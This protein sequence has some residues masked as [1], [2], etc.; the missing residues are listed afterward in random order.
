M[1]TMGDMMI[2]SLE[3]DEALS[4]QTT[5]CDSLPIKVVKATWIDSARRLFGE[6]KDI[7]M[8]AQKH[9][10]LDFQLRYEY[11]IL[12]SDSMSAVR[13]HL[14]MTLRYYTDAS[15]SLRDRDLLDDDA[16]GPMGT[17]QRAA[18]PETGKPGLVPALGMLL[19]KTEGG[20]NQMVAKRQHF[21]DLQKAKDDSPSA[22]AAAQ[23]DDVLIKSPDVVS[24]VFAPH[25]IHAYLELRY[26]KARE[27]RMTLLR[28]LNFFRSVER[29]LVH[30]LERS[31]WSDRDTLDPMAFDTGAP[32]R[33]ADGTIIKP[34]LDL[35]HALE[36]H[37]LDKG[38][39]DRRLAIDRHIYIS[40]NDGENVIYDISYQDLATL[41]GRLLRMASA[42]IS[43]SAKDAEATDDFFMQHARSKLR[44]HR[45]FMDV[46]F[47]A[48]EIDRQQILLELLSSQVELNDSKINLV[49]AMMEVYE[50]VYAPSAK[51]ALSNRVVQVMAAPRAVDPKGELVSGMTVAQIKAYEAQE[52]LVV[53]LLKHAVRTQ[54]SS[55]WGSIVFHH[56][57]VPAV[58]IS[59]FMW[60]LD[61]IPELQAHVEMLAH[62]LH[63]ALVPHETVSPALLQSA[64]WQR[65][66]HHWI[67]LAT[68]AFQL[69]ETPRK[70]LFQQDLITRP[71]TFSQLLADQYTADN[72]GVETIVHPTMGH[73]LAAS[74]D[75]DPNYA[76][77]ACKYATSY[78]ELL[79]AYR[80][81]KG[82]WL[83]T[84]W[85]HQ[86]LRQQAASM[87]VSF[88][89]FCPNFAPLPFDLAEMGDLHIFLTTKMQALQSVV[90]G[91]RHREKR[92]AHQ[93]RAHRLL[94]PSL[95][96][97][98]ATLSL[99]QT[100]FC[101]S[102]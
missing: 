36:T 2:Q 82:Q 66:V 102:L 15:L 5:G 63:I 94:F 86:S 3:S 56:A 78:S 83:E 76:E 57:G 27:L 72:S 75:T 84:H 18:S 23:L 51:R 61:G 67:R 79:D 1:Q 47:N 44:D 64:V 100:P 101:A 11:D 39:E 50:H 49:N 88:K 41:E 29:R 91:P 89:L 93:N 31:N 21:S 34:A 95:M 14:R 40:N 35:A 73:C 52:R 59:E 30:D 97:R 99:R 55:D 32:I 33:E 60:G 38:A 96:H 87:G 98:G 9:E 46:S 71:E 6:I 17:R 92:H 69:P 26:I 13:D 65:T 25:E 37:T 68:T 48:P 54:S 70:L 81:L 90:V 85:L 19:P 7:D 8:L 62:D 10:R 42:M 58:H 74:P 53:E 24:T 28:Q 77:V 12:A 45:D 16:S 20:V 43:R 22:A 4:K 80:R